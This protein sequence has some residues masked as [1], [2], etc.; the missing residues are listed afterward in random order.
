MTR[1]RCATEAD[2]ASLVAIYAPYVATAV[3]FETS[4]PSVAEFAR[5]IRDISSFYPYLVCETE[6]RLVGYAYAHRMYE[7]AAYDWDVELSVYVAQGE[8]AKGVGSALYEALIPL[9]RKQH[10]VNLY[11][12]ISL[13][14][15]ASV[16][17]HRK[18]GFRELGVWRRTGYKDGAWHD[19]LCME[20]QV[21][22]TDTAPQPL[23]SWHEVKQ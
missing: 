13:P 21:G 6:G 23:R 2:A 5:R 3:T 18:F 19:V 7:R 16:A 10:I 20:A 15:E 12:L 4:V 1:I 11:A 9:L 14:N 8:G 22:E 17:L